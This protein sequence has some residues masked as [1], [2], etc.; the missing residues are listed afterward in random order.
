MTTSASS[1]ASAGAAAAAA[2][3]AAAQGAG[4]GGPSKQPLDL[5]GI[6]L[7]AATELEG[8]HLSL[9]YPPAKRNVVAP[10]TLAL[11]ESTG[12][13][14]PGKWEYRATPMAAQRLRSGAARTAA[15][16]LPSVIL[17]PAL[18]P[19]ESVCR[20]GPLELCVSDTAFVGWP[21]QVPRPK[22]S[23]AVQSRVT[24]VHVVFVLARGRDEHGA[25]P[26]LVKISR[27]ISQSLVH[28]ELR[29][30]WLSAEVAKLTRARDMWLRAQNVPGPDGYKPDMLDLTEYLLQISPLCSQLRDVFHRM[31]LSGTA[32]VCFNGWTSLSIS[33][34]DPAMRI[35]ASL[36]PYHALFLVDHELSDLSFR[37]S[38]AMACLLTHAKPSKT[39]KELEVETGIPLKHIYELVSHLVYWRCAL[40]KTV[41]ARENVYLLNPRPLLPICSQPTTLAALFARDCPAKKLTDLLREFDRCR[42][43]GEHIDEACAAAGQDPLGQLEASAVGKELVQ[44]VCWLL[45]HDLLVQVHTFAYLVMP[46]GVA[47]ADVDDGSLAF[48]LFARVAPLL[49]G[50]HHTDEIKWRANISRA[51]LEALFTRY[52]AYVVVVHHRD[53]E[54]IEM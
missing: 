16:E 53:I 27:Q 44:H 12:S 33:L 36:R 30:G 19:R 38:P 24:S 3:A 37:C 46:P 47:L 13:A 26:Q 9:R 2:A 25:A 51:D 32:Q 52:A 29:C 18:M 40:V 34:W 41:V 21:T 10:E 22:S 7:V 15:Y 8:A 1:A 31:R 43:L 14:A 45:A 17:A 6:L 4:A 35:N 23:A 28:E 49:D 54:R 5:V 39:L 20:G 48:K 50:H 11:C 42:T